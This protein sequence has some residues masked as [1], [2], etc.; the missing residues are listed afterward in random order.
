MGSFAAIAQSQ[1]RTLPGPL[2][3]RQPMVLL[4]VN[5]EQAVMG[6]AGAHWLDGAGGDTRSTTCPGAAG[7]QSR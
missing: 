2:M 6:I 7:A 5:E 3:V 4:F 1:I